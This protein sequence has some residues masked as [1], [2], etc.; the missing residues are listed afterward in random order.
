MGRIGWDG[1]SMLRAEI[2]PLRNCR[3]STWFKPY[4]CSWDDAVLS[5]WGGVCVGLGTENYCRIEPYVIADG[6]EA[7]DSIGIHNGSSQNTLEMWSFKLH[8]AETASISPADN[9]RPPLCSIWNWMW[10]SGQSCEKIDKFDNVRLIFIISSDW[11]GVVST[12]THL[13]N[14]K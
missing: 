1:L 14:K 4:T 9:P 2:G 3:I 11:T 5:N 12:S 13:H 7:I 10:K 8:P 6:P